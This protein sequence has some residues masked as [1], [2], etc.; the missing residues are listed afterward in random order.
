VLAAQLAREGM[1]AAES[2]LRQAAARQEDG[3]GA[4]FKGTRYEALLHAP[5]AHAADDA[6]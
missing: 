3:A 4:L 6:R 5:G 1:T 2:A